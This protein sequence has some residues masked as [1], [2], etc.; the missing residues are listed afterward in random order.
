MLARGSVSVGSEPPNNFAE[1]I[2]TRVVVNGAGKLGRAII[3]AS[4][5]QDGP[6]SVV[7]AVDRAEV[8]DLPVPLY[9]SL[10]LVTEDFDALIDASRAEGL[11]T[12]LEFAARENKPLLI[13]ATGH[14]GPQLEALEEAAQQIPVL[15][16]SNLSIGVNVVRALT[17]AAGKMLGPVDA[18]IVETHHR[19][20]VDAPSGTALT[21]AQT[22]RDATDPQ[23]EFVY[24]RTPED[25][26]ARGNE[27][28]IHAVRGGSVV[29]EHSVTFLLDDEIVE[30]RHVA[31]SR[32]IFGSA[33]LRAAQ[34]IQ[35][36]APGLYEMA[37]LLVAD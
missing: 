1:A 9:S 21:L 32:K 15:L 3:A 2:L 35:H 5:E 14:S 37:D 4:L 18:E 22:L 10:D 12:V 25:D 20:K 27:I 23:R 11:E 13:A 8:E 7:A 33:A 30:I 17:E 16:S 28:G 34:F 31:Q 29:G 24:G 36:Q 26:S 19:M 6:V